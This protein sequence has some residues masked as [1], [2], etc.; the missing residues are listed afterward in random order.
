MSTFSQMADLEYL[1]ADEVQKLQHIFTVVDT[2]KD[3]S[4][5]KSEIAQLF[6]AIGVV[7]HL[8][9]F[10]SV[11]M[12]DYV[13]FEFRRKTVSWRLRRPLRGLMPT[14]TGRLISGSF[15]NSSS[16]RSKVP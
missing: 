6:Q 14:A 2:N 10:F 4:L 13:T 8:R 5:S 9:T 16:A 11:Q 12:F 3:G 1:T 15:A 7:C